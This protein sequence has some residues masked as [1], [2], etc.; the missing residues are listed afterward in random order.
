MQLLWFW[1]DAEN[2][3]NPVG[4]PSEEAA[5]HMHTQTHVEGRGEHVERRMDDRGEWLARAHRLYM[6]EE[7][8]LVPPPPLSLSIYLYI[9]LSLSL[10]SRLHLTH[11]CSMNVC[12][13]F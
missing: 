8:V 1:Y 10:S 3:D 7:Q 9:G 4:P 2:P 12:I 6:S 13:I 5:G 11:M